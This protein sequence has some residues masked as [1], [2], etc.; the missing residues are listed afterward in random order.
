MAAGGGEIE[1]FDGLI[2]VEQHLPV[3]LLYRRRGLLVGLLVV[4]HLIVGAVV[5]M[6]AELAVG[7]ALNLPVSV[8]P[9]AHGLSF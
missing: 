3:G 9:G 5:H 4:V 1:R 6:S 8:R 7:V 2:L